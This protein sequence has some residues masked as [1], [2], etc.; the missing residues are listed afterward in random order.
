MAM[1]GNGNAPNTPNPFTQTAAGRTP[2]GAPNIP[3]AG[4]YQP[5]QDPTMR[6][7]VGNGRVAPRIP[8]GRAIPTGIQGIPDV[9]T[10]DPYQDPTV[11]AM[12]GG[13]PTP[14]RPGPTATSYAN[15]LFSGGAAPDIPGI[16]ANAA[17]TNLASKYTPGGPKNQFMN[18]W[19]YGNPDTGYQTA[20]SQGE[21][22]ARA[23]YGG[24]FDVGGKGSKATKL[25]P[26]IAGQSKKARTAADKAFEQANT[27]RFRATQATT[28]DRDTAMQAAGQAY[29]MANLL[30]RTPFLDA[31]VQRQLGGRAQ[32][33]RI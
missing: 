16:Q 28:P 7:M 21:A 5:Y 17:L 31:M 23:L 26:E 1:V 32:G 8:G 15:Q 14:A 30:G 12:V 25:T 22:M 6:A 3:S 18:Q 11:A 29:A 33:L 20:G 2:P 24:F 19:V 13:A 27:K 9:G 4:T 10:Y